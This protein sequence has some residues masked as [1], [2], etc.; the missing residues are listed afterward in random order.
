MT[1][2]SL[3]DETGKVPQSLTYDARGDLASVADGNG[4]QT[5]YTRD[6]VGN[7]TKVRDARNNETNFEYDQGDRLTKKTLPDG[8]FEQYTY[9]GMG[10]LAS[11]RLPDGHTNAFKYDVRNRL[12]EID[13]FDGTITTYTYT[14]TGKRKTATT[15][16]GTVQY[17]YDNLDRLIKITQPNGQSVNY[18]YD[19][20]DNVTAVTT[21][22]GSTQYTW[23]DANRLKTV[24]DPAGATTTFTYDAAGRLTTRTL[25][26]SIVTTYSYDLNDRLTKVAH[27]HGA[28]PAFRSFTYT[29]DPAGNRQAVVEDD[30]S[31]T[32]WTYDNAYRLTHEVSKNGANVV[33]SDIAYTYDAAG[34]RISKTQNGTTTNYQYNTLDQLTSAG[35]AQYS[36]DA[37]GN[38]IGTIDGAATTAYTWDPANRMT[39]FTSSTGGS[40]A[41]TYDADGR[42]TSRSEGGVIQGFL[43]DES[44]PFGEIVLETDGAGNP[45]AT[46]ARASSEVIGRFAG[47]ARSYYLHDGLGNV[48]GL[49]DAA[50]VVTDQYQY[51]AWGQV[52]TSQGSTVNPYGYRGQ[53]T[54]P[55][56]KLLQL[57]ARWFGPGIG[58]FLSRDM[59]E[60]KLD[61]PVDLNRYGYAA[62]NPINQ[63]DPTGHQAAVEYGVLARQSAENATIEGYLIGRR[64]ETLISC[65][66]NILGAMLAKEFLAGSFL[67]AGV[68]PPWAGLKNVITVA[69]GHLVKAPLDAPGKDWQ[70]NPGD[71]EG[72]KVLL[73]KASLFSSAPREETMALSGTRFRIPK[74]FNDA[75]N[76]FVGR[77]G[78]RL[79]SDQ[80]EGADPCNNHAEQ[81]LLRDANP[82]SQTLFSVGAS[83]P[84]CV[85][86]FMQLLPWVECFGPLG[87]N[88]RCVRE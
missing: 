58:R 51:D 83:R 50:G 1:Y 48:I 41:Y 82:P 79:V 10:H 62:A 13:Y 47:A 34:N 52:T 15:A 27:S 56:N 23:D 69:L 11:V 33:I 18:T 76:F 75:L 60:W 85:N 29:L 38:L 31:R 43:W 53:R 71:E 6:S 8:S 49:S 45:T 59:M 4:N 9:D 22:A 44:T 21:A 26:N 46:Y 81:K 87:G 42:W 35:T 67:P 86:C 17:S 20:A 16:A 61:N 63:Y 78:F 72:R 3:K 2:K 32:D 36:Y 30:G 55:L 68:K 5:T 74:V 73:W 14:G 7:I 65:V 64:D 84:V 12:R 25:P 28:G 54:D 66:A 40:A 37:R 19:A 77:L 57:R 88:M 39:S 24:I 70:F 80:Q